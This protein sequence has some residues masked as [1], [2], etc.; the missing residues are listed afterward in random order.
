M[1]EP[2]PRLTWGHININV[3]NLDHSL[4]FYRKLGFDVFIPAVPYL[5]LTL[6]PEPKLLEDSVADALGVPRDTY[7]RACIVQLDDGFPKVDLIE[8]SCSPQASPLSNA[9]LGVVRICLVSGDLAAD[10]ARLEGE[11]VKFIAP[12]ATGVAELAEVA[13][14]RDPDGSLIE[15]LQVYLEKWQALL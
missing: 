14:C 2:M 6:E 12:P 10:V 7:G 3:S 15:I 13:V 11:G 4:A 1:S 9:D 5:G 8:L